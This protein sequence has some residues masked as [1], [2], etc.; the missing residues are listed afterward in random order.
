LPKAVATADTLA[1]VQASARHRSAGAALVAPQAASRATLV[2][3]LRAARSQSVATIVAPAGYGKTTLLAQWAARDDRRFVWAPVDRRDTGAA[4]LLRRVADALLGEPTNGTRAAAD[5]GSTALARVAT[6][7]RHSPDPVVLVLDDAHLLKPAAASLVTSLIG[8][9]PPESMVVLAGRARPALPGCP[10][11]RLRARGQLLELGARELALTRREAQAALHGFGASLPADELSALL[12]ETEG[13]AAGIAV[14]AGRLRESGAAWPSGGLSQNAE[15]GDWI[16]SECLDALPPTQRAF[17]A[18][19]SVLDR[20]SGPLCDAVLEQ[21]GSQ[22]V[23]ESLEE[24]SLFLAPLDR[25]QEWFRYHPLFRE[26]LKND[27]RAREPE[28]LPILHRRAADWFERHGDEESALEHAHAAGDIRRFSRIFESVAFA[29]RNSGRDST[30]ERWLARVE[31]AAMLEENPEVAVVAA[32]LHALRGRRAEVEVLVV[33]AVHSL[34]RLPQREDED[35][36]RAKLD[37]VQAAMCAGGPGPMLA[38]VES[39]LEVI[40]ADDSWRPFALL[41]QGVAYALLGEVERGDAILGRAA[42][43]AERL[44]SVETRVLAL[45][46]RALIAESREEHDNAE[47]LLRRARDSGAGRLDGYGTYAL[48]LAASARLLLRHGRWTDARAALEAARRLLPSLGASLPWLAVQARL[49][50]AAA[51]VMLRDAAAAQALTAQIDQLV[52]QSCDPALLRLPR[53]T[54]G[55][56]IAEIPPTEVGRTAALTAA[57]LRLLPLLATHLSFREIGTTLFLSRHTVKTQ[58]I[59]L[60]R[61]LG[62]SS[63]SGAVEHAE[64]LGLVDPAEFPASLMPSG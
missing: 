16:R 45:T 2:N 58:A 9:A 23:L 56:A 19:T 27:L 26:H 51:Y 40:S 12:D 49:E 10:L 11:P 18:R 50:L 33:G 46:E 52:E 64:L 32:R 3:R 44:R 59:S 53:E 13:W 41:L 24:A 31:E 28:L 20:I 55:R 22:G 14:A 35:L 38:G 6:C 60:Y 36:L 39:A 63:R 37:L 5:A 62:V 34:A 25:R 61:K 54:I 47:T 30:V 29:I 17:L 7:W 43:A 57:E 48:T 4:A 21:T 8:L 42:H 1:P 15:L